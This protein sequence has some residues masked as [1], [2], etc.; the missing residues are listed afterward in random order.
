MTRASRGLVL[1]NEVGGYVASLEGAFGFLQVS[2]AN[3]HFDSFELSFRVFAFRVFAFRV[4]AFRVF[5]QSV[6]NLKHPLR[7]Y[8]APFPRRIPNKVPTGFGKGGAQSLPPHFTLNQ[9][10]AQF[11]AL[12]PY[13]VDH[14]H[15]S[16]RKKGPEPLLS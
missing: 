15:S 2:A 1:R 7:A 9:A 6:N 10:Q 8:V 14:P 13:R 4:L 12:N 5:A 3:K 16:S 11:V